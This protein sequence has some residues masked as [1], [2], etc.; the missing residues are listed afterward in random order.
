MRE[1]VNQ[2]EPFLRFSLFW[3]RC[4]LCIIVHFIWQI[5]LSKLMCIQAIHFYQYVHSLGLK[6]TAMPLLSSF[7]WATDIKSCGLTVLS[8]SSIGETSMWPLL[9]SFQNMV[10]LHWIIVF[11]L[12][13]KWTKS[14]SFF[15]QYNR[16]KS[17]S[18]SA[19]M[20]QNKP[21]CFK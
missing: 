15:L 9:K 13:T 4:L 17:V 16:F 20:R 6:S 14:S 10:Q 1:G 18:V 11:F 3:M 12:D 2:Q 19:V 5:L 8:G 7:S 21:K